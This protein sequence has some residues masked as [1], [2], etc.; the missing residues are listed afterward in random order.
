M[1]WLKLCK[2]KITYKLFTYKSYRYNNLNVYKQMTGVNLDCYCY[3]A[4]IE[5]I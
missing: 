4:I 5:T 2:N 3:I 1:N